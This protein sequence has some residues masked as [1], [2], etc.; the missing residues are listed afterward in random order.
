ML[1]ALFYRAEFAGE[2]IPTLE[3][4]LSLCDELQIQV[5]VEV[6]RDYDRSVKAITDCL[7]KLPSLYQLVA[8]ISFFPTALYKVSL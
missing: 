6:K 7:K 5:F 8:V 3:E 4:A 1:V 2:Q